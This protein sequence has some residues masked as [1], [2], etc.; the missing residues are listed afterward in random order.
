MVTWPTDATREHLDSGTDDPKLARAEINDAVVK[1]NALRDAARDS[2]EKVESATGVQQ[3]VDALGDRLMRANSVSEM[4]SL[5]LAK[6]SDGQRVSVL[7]YHAPTFPSARFVGG[8]EF[9]WDSA[10]TEADN[11]GTCFEV[12]G[13]TTGR[14]K[15]RVSGPTDV[16]WFGAVGDGARDN[17]AEIN[18]AYAYAG[19]VEG[20]FGG[21]VVFPAGV[22]EVSGPINVA[23]F[24]VNTEG[25]NDY[26][27]IVRAA[28]EFVGDSI[29]LF[30]RADQG[31]FTAAGMKNIGVNCNLQACHGITHK[32]A[33]DTTHLEGV[34]VYGA[35]ADRHAWRVVPN[36][37]PG[38][39]QTVTAINCLFSKGE[40]G[41]NET[42]RLEKVQEAVLTMVKMW[43]GGSTDA[44]GNNFPMRIVGCRSVVMVQP[45]FVSTSSYGL[46]IEDGSRSITGIHLID[47]LF[48]NCTG[49][50]VFADSSDA[51][52]YPITGL[53]VTNPR[54]EQPSGGGFA[55]YG[56]FAS[57]IETNFTSVEFGPTSER[58]IVVSNQTVAITDNGLYNVKIR[59]GDSSNP[60]YT[61]E[62]K[63]GSEIR[64]GFYVH[65]RFDDADESLKTALSLGLNIAGSAGVRRVY[66][67]SPDS[68]GTGYRTLRVPN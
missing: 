13:V 33:Y 4:L 17:V 41:T 29:F 1:L 23:D 59:P 51:S 21:K 49:G 27:T 34:R 55:L 38:I 44:P 5:D 53:R 10:S 7:S 8:G 48:E 31:V 61:I 42:V 11:G 32:A 16:T 46:K 63:Q 47:P 22:F 35:K 65:A 40:P 18:A 6:I 36:G 43:N 62:S 37:S 64:S 45:S 68:A 28:A 9:Y 67:G 39:S 15:R 56:V 14:W 2:V 25:E 20:T 66:I 26:A 54:I 24:G 58:N 3:L 60:M 57:H 12:S 52:L 30:E 50:T 19:S